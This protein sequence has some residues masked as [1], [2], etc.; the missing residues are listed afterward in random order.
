MLLLYGIHVSVQTIGRQAPQVV[1]KV[2]YVIFNAIGN[3][4]SVC[5]VHTE[6]GGDE[7]AVTYV[8]AMTCLQ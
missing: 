5:A 7:S 2:D 1:E 6:T 4:L 8:S 3:E